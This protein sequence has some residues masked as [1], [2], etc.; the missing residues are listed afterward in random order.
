M[1]AKCVM[2]DEQFRLVTE[3]RQSGLSD[4]R[5]GNGSD[6]HGGDPQRDHLHAAEGVLYCDRLF[7][8]ERSYMVESKFGMFLIRNL[9]DKL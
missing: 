9:G 8:L 5:N 4:L 3:C 6:R 2:P 1:R 7:S